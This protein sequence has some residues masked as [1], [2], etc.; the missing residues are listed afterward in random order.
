MEPL[1]IEDTLAP[2]QGGDRHCRESAGSRSLV[3]QPLWLTARET[4]L[5]IS[6][7]ARASPSP[8]EREQELFTRLSE[9]HRSFGR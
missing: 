2:H 8:G 5:L 4:E 3:R 9:F 6:L 1:A 7:C